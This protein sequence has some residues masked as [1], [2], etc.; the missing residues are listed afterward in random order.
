MTQYNTLNVKLSNSQLNKLKSGIKNR[1]EVTLKLSSN[2]IGNFNDETKISHKLLLTSTQVS[3]IHKVFAN[4]LSANINFSKTQLSNIQSGGF[5]T[6][7]FGISV[8]SDIKSG[9]DNFI[10]SP[11]KLLNSYE[12]ELSNTDT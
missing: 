6:D 10:E 9:L 5:M 1:T 8:V 2:L 4:G 3:M 12:K 11:F 7:I